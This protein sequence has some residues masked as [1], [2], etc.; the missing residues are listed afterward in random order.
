VP[1]VGE[2]VVKW[3]QPV[4]ERRERR[5]RWAGG[6]SWAGKKDAPAVVKWA[7]RKGER[8][9]E[10]EE[11]RWVVARL[12][13]E[14]E[15]ERRGFG[16]S[17]FQTPFQTFKFFSNLNTTNPIQIILKLLKLHTNNKHYATKR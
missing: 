7:G 17:F 8:K 11:G 5:E 9:R 6:I 4:G 15:G 16:F 12:K 14:K 1:E 2:R 13:I 10:G 3:G